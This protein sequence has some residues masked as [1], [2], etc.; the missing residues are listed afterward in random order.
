MGFLRNWAGVLSR[1][2]LRNV[3]VVGLVRSLVSMSSLS[4]HHTIPREKTFWTI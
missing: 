4:V 1:V 2:G 3:L